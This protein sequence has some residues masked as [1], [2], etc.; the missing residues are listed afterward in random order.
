MKKPIYFIGFL[1]LFFLFVNCSN[2]TSNSEDVSDTEVTQRSESTSLEANGSVSV[3]GKAPQDT[4]SVDTFEVWVKNWKEHGKEWVDSNG[5]E[6]FNM[7]LVDLEEL[8]GETGVDSS[9]FYL[10]LEMKN[11]NYMPKLVLVGVDSTGKIMTKTAQGQY[12]FDYTK[13]CPPYCDKPK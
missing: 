8:Y 5:L 7:P 1:S 13:A 11:G 9:R 10:G 6:Y 3:T 2:F 4:I 12:L